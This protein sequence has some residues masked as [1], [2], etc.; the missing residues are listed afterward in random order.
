MN[1]VLFITAIS[2]LDCP[3]PVR[4]LR[5]VFPQNCPAETN[6]E[7]LKYRFSR[8]CVRP[9]SVAVSTVAPGAQLARD[10]VTPNRLAP[11]LSVIEIGVPDCTVATPLIC[12]P[13]KNF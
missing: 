8:S 3:G 6:A 9:D 5:P 1:D 10:E 7:V 11:R 12:Q 4:M 2:M 13:L